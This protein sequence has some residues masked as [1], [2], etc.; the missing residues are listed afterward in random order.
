MQVLVDCVTA[1]SSHGCEGGDPTAAYS[2]I[3][4][5]GV[6]DQT[7]SNYQAKDDT[8]TDV[9]TCKSCDWNGCWAIPRKQYKTYFILEHG[10]VGRARWP[11]GNLVHTHC[12]AKLPAVHALR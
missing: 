5:H 3:L 6:P 7:C 10:Q 12:P 11:M 2:W 8:C 4:R 9:N 1:N